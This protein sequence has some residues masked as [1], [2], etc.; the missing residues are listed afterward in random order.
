MGN[1]QKVGAN[2]EKSKGGGWRVENGKVE[3]GK[4]ACEENIKPASPQ[5]TLPHFEALLIRRELQG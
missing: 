3:I 2:A 5:E 4:A 1:G